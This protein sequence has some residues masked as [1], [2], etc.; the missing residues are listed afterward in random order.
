[1][2]GVVLYDAHTSL[3]QEQLLLVG[4]VREGIQIPKTAHKAKIV[5][6]LLSPKQL[7]VKDHLRGV[8][9]AARLIRPG[10]SV[11]KL[12]SAESPE[13]VYSILLKQ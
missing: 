5:L 12:L 9:R 2:A 6:M 7:S 3:V 10:D 13:E 4:V 1:M 11:N 8:N